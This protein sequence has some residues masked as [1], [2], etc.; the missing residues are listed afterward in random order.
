M[1]LTRKGPRVAP[2]GPNVFDDM[3]KNPC[4][5]HKTPVNHTLEQCVDGEILST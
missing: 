3:L 1:V 4:L 2:R 5:Y